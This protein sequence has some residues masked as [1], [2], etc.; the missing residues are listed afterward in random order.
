MDDSDDSE[1]EAEG[2]RRERVAAGGSDG[3]AKKIEDTA[4]LLRK[5]SRFDVCSFDD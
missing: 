3:D 1:D 4:A 2:E 5:A